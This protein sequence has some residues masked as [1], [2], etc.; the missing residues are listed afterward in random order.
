MK[1]FNLTFLFDGKFHD[2]ELTAEHLGALY[3]YSTILTNIDNVDEY[4][5]LSDLFR[6]RNKITKNEINKIFDNIDIRWLYKG[7]TYRIYLDFFYDSLKIC[8]DEESE[9]ISST[10][11]VSTEYVITEK[12]D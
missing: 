1:R 7:K 12:N 3:A 2:I 8:S 10:E 9:F 11:Y 5:K 6:E 4:D